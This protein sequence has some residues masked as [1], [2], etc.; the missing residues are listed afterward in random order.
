MKNSTL[1]L[2]F[3]KYIIYKCQKS[4]IYHGYENKGRSAI[5]DIVG[6]DSFG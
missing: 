5:K 6:N 1:D 4:G 2:T 3:F